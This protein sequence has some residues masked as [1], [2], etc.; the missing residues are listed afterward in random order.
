MTLRY[1]LST[2]RYR[3]FA[4]RK[5]RVKCGE[6]SA[7]AR[8]S[9]SGLALLLRPCKQ[10]VNFCTVPSRASEAHIRM[11]GRRRPVQGPIPQRRQKL[12]TLLRS[13]EWQI[14]P[15]LPTKLFPRAGSVSQ[16]SIRLFGILGKS[17]LVIFPK[18]V[19]E[20]TSFCRAVPIQPDWCFN[21]AIPN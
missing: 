7:Y 16:Q 5:G 3:T 11:N 18:L 20:L 8:Y 13:S 12:R 9:G 1:L 4:S 19:K 17:R 6:N 10:M 2:V 21:G 14:S 15:F